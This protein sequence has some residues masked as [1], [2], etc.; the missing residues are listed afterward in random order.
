LFKGEK[1]KLAKKNNEI[2]EE[3]KKLENRYIEIAI[4]SLRLSNSDINPLLRHNC[5]LVV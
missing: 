4:P 2:K 3:R 5:V 1:K